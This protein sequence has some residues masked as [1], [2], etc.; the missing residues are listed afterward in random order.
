MRSQSARHAHVRWVL[1]PG[2]Q[3]ISKATKAP[4]GKLGQAKSGNPSDILVNPTTQAKTRSHSIIPV[5]NRA[6]SLPLVHAEVRG[7]RPHCVFEPEPTR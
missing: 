4:A 2:R 6:A 3:F 5:G 7:G 1:K